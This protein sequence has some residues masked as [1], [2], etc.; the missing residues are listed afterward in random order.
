M[1]AEKT[2]ILCILS[3]LQKYS[4]ADH[5]LTIK[6]I[7]NKMKLLYGVELDR[8]T[9][10]RNIDLLIDFG[11]DIS[12]YEENNTGYYLRERDFEPSEL[13]MLADAVLTADCIP[14]RHGKNLIRK[15]QQ[16]GSVH[17]TASLDRLIRVKT[18]KKEPNKQIFLT[19]ELL[20]EAIRLKR[21]VEFN[22]IK[23][24]TNL[25]K[26]PRRKEKYVVSPYALYWNNN[27]YYLI[28]NIQP[29][30]DLCHFRL[31][32]IENISIKDSPSLPAPKGIDVYEYAS[33]ALFMFGGE[34]ETYTIQCDNSIINDVVDRFG[35]DIIII[36]S[37]DE[38]FTAVVKATT[39]GMRLW[40]IHYIEKCKVIEP[41]WLVNEVVEA[42]KKAM[43]NYSISP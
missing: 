32:R 13:H 23:Y 4:D 16:L 41:E 15:L 34:T 6:D 25:K 31:D 28:S 17:Q 2:Y 37:D 30:K 35:D 38:T 19:I 9:V 11:Y 14:E 39:L 27:Q 18:N 12:T 20:D 43:K 21:Q 26:V 5:I 8:R 29:Y 1:L 42:I 36:D 22:Y 7:L 40:A 33:N 3:I 10:Y 24:D